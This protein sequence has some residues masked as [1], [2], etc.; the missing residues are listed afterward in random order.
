MSLSWWLRSAAALWIAATLFWAASGNLAQEL[1]MLAWTVVIVLVFV[2]AGM[3]GYFPWQDHADFRGRRTPRV[4]RYLFIS[5]GAALLVNYGAPMTLV[6]IHA[7][8]ERL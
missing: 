1:S 6:A 7:I 2:G 4:R 8:G 3:H 5:I